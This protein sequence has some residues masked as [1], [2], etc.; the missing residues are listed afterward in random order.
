[1]N[2]IKKTKVILILFLSLMAFPTEIS[3][4][5]T[6]KVE[7]PPRYKIWLEAEVNY[8]IT[9]VE[10]EVFLKLQT[11]RERNLFVDFFSDPD[12]LR[13]SVQLLSDRV[14]ARHIGDSS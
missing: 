6:S 7:L 9:S 14:A 8:I 13:S 12:A 3:S 11:D 5:V 10:K 1:M 4:I 2:P